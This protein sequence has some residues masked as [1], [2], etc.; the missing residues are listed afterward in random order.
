MTLSLR[1]ATQ[2]D[3]AAIARISAAAFHPTT[4]AITRQLFPL[5]LKPEDAQDGEAAYHWRA[6]RKSNSMHSKRTA[7]IVAVD[8]SLDG[9]VVGFA[10][11]ESPA[12]PED[13]VEVAHKEPEP[14]AALDRA[15]F[16]E[17]KSIVSADATETFGERG[18][19]DVWHLDYIGIE[20]KHQRRGIGRMLLEWGIKHAEKDD[21]EC[22]LVA[23]PAGRPLYLA[24][25][26]ED[27]RTLQIFGVP[28][29]SMILRR[30]SAKV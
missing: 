11:W 13:A 5:G 9:E 4:D 16:A 25:G 7:M 22:Y 1:E 24:Y 30:R 17:M 23:T 28:H 15:A 12:G 10:L 19:K 26:F 2:Q 20:P 6:A 27:V 29:S 8:D 14:P 21:R 18:M 3:V